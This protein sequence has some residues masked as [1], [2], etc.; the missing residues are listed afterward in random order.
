MGI[1]YDVKGL[2]NLLDEGGIVLINHQS[3]WD[4]VVL[5]YI[6]PHLGPAAVI[7]KKEI[8]YYPPVGPAIWSYG[9]VFVDRSNRKAALKSIELASKAI[10]EQK[11]KLI[12]FPEG[13]RSISPTLR[14]FKNGAFIS[15]FDNKCKVFPVV[16]PQFKFIDHVKKTF[17]PG[18][19]SISLL[20][21]VD[22]KDFESF[23]ALRDHCQVVMQKEYDQLNSVSS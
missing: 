10:H 21:A 12:F 7:A 19:K 18:K 13:T 6:W 5:A 22:S 17:T 15:A 16:A 8:I 3:F 11:K 14:G 23:E 9:S 4:L 20:K 2:N 1:E